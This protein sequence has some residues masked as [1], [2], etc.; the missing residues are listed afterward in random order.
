MLDS[1]KRQLSAHF[2]VTIVDKI[3]EHYQALKTAYRLQDWEKCLLRA[4]KFAETVM[5]G[6]HFLRTGQLVSSISVEREINEVANRTDL[7][8]SIR[9]LIPRSVRVLYDHRSRRG[10]AHSHPLD[11][12][13]MDC[14]LAA[15]LAD[16][17]LAELVRLYYTTDP[18][19]A[20]SIVRALIAKSIPIVER[21]GED[22]VVLSPGASAREEI[23]L[24][25][26]SRYPERTT[27]AQLKRWMPHQSPGN[28]ST[29]LLNMEKA[30]QIHRS[31]DG[32]VLTSLG[33]RV[34][35]KETAPQ[36]E[37]ARA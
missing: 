3:L 6:I 10:G 1:I 9:L 25:L 33:V 16:W 20:A 35:E 37:S 32:A 22:Y 2:D 17:V 7:D 24:I 5:K 13:P 11:L 23:G 15:S 30:K 29:S 34:V 26:H 12:N 19:Q 31:S 27:T 8:D 28:I 36:F 4:G 14:T 18:E 21:I